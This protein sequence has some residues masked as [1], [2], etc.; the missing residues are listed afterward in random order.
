[1]QKK[2]TCAGVLVF[3]VG[4]FAELGEKIYLDIHRRQYMVDYVCCDGFGDTLDRALLHTC[5][6]HRGDHGGRRRR[7][8]RRSIL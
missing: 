6:A 3:A 5:H 8:L 1:M 4:V 2:N 7:Q